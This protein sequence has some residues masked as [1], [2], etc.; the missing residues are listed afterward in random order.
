MRTVTAV[1]SGVV[2]IVGFG[3]AQGTGNRS[4]GG[5]I[6]VIGATYCAIQ[7]WRRAGA[8]RAVL[9]VAIFSIAFVVS[10]PLGKVIGSWPSVLLVSLI[11][12]VST[13][14]LTQPRSG[15]VEIQG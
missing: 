2:L 12:A 14:A 13:Y 10:H 11:T 5:V 6:L 8:L 15:V 1:M 9:S 4:L 3:V 7:W